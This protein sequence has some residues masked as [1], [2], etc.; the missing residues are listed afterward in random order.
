MKKMINKYIFFVLL[1]I[2]SVGVIIYGI[3]CLRKD[4]E[5][6]MTDEEKSMLCM[7]YTDDEN[8]MNGKLYDF[9]IEGLKQ[10]RMAKEYLCEKYPGY[11]YNFYYFSPSDAYHSLCT[12]EFLVDGCEDYFTVQ[13][14]V[15][16]DGCIIRDN[17]Y[18]YVLGPVYNEMLTEKFAEAGLENFVVHTRFGGYVGKEVDASISMDDFIEQMKS[19]NVNVYVYI[20]MLGEN[21]EVNK[22]IAELIE[23]QLRDIEN[24]GSHKIFFSVGITEH[25]STWEEGFEYNEENG[26]IVIE[27][28]TRK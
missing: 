5:I 22:Q 10:F 28:D 20:D 14:T 23:K 27:L 7:A 6:Y 11:E 4:K 25:C 8:I 3:C 26:G 16:E 1:G 9:H 15:T 13:I 12:L 17:F 18:E 24:N 19:H 21:D 2:C